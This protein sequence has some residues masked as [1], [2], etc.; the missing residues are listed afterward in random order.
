M[1]TEILD[2]EDC[3]ALKAALK[4]AAPPSFSPSRTALVHLNMEPIAEQLRQSFSDFNWFDH[5]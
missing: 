1:Y 2:A 5:I 4:V 3:K